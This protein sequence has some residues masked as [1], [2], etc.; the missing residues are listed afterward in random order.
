M[1]KPLTKTSKDG[2][3]Y[4]RPRLVKENIES[5]IGL[6]IEAIK[7]RLKEG[8]PDSESYLR[9]ECLVYLFREA[10]SRRDDAMANLLAMALLTR[11]E[12]ILRSKL[13][14][15]SKRLNEEI[16]ADFA[17]LLANDGS[18]KLDYYEI[19][20]NHAFRAHR[21][22]MV[23]TEVNRCK[24]VGTYKLE[25]N[26]DSDEDGFQ[27]DEPSCNP[28]VCDELI[29]NELLEQLPPEIRKAIVLREM[30]YPIESNDSTEDTVATLCGVSERT[31]H[32]WIKKAQAILLNP[33]KESA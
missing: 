11:C 7:A 6:G 24:K 12:A 30:G 31:I 27:T 1:I 10:R 3:V 13:T 28:I 9:S 2:K 23:R 22:E 25:A 32:N 4:S 15:V 29:R 14:N 18:N 33:S 17:V 8:N 20:F 16:L 21:L 19:R 26:A 5:A